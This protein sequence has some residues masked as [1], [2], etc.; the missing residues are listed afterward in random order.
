M[1][2]ALMLQ[3]TGSDVGKSV[4]VAGL[5]RLA[6]RRGLR[7]APFK[8][9]NMSNNAAVCAGGGEIGRAQALQA[10][11][12]GIEP[13]ADLNPVLLKPESNTRAQVVV[14]GRALASSEAADYMAGR[15]NLL[16][17]VLESFHRLADQHE[18]VLV[19]GAGSPAEINL[20]SGDIANM[21][22]ARAAGVPVCLIGDID[23]GGVI[24]SLVGTHNVMAAEDAAMVRSFLVNKFRGDPRLFDEGNTAIEQRTGWPCRGLIPWMSEAARLPAEDAVVLESNDCSERALRIVAPLLSRIANFDDADPLIQ[25]PGVDFCWIAPGDPL[26]RDADVVLL[27]GSKSTLGELAFLRQQGWDHDLIAHARTGGRILG[28]CGGL[29]ML[30][31]TVTDSCGSDGSPGST[32][33]LGLLDLHTTMH[34]DKTLARRKARCALTGATIEAYEIHQGVSSGSDAARPMAWI[35][36]RPEGHRS[37][38]G[39]IEGTYLHGLFSNDDYRRQWL[40]RAG[41]STVSTLAYEHRVEL[42]L[43][44]IADGLA[45]HVDFEALLR[46]AQ[47]PGWTP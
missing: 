15:R 5:C 6:T 12:A 23:R 30:G 38:C 41:A 3:G 39:R 14:Q 27:F 17:A 18:L 7:V 20:R 10:R 13:V 24:A 28:I 45:E 36:D 1:T 25:E 34:T 37:A 16:P 35:D 46:D 33:G 44:R 31:V 40:Q 22:F 43:D 9:Q 32:E 2:R 11:A 29:Q 47:P 19:E 8:S 4:L 26:P 21:G 42:A